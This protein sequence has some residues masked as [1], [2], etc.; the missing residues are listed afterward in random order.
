MN[1]INEVL[2]YMT[3]NLDES[4]LVFVFWKT[5]TAGAAK[6]KTDNLPWA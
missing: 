4:D 5:G 1:N 3:H 6:F 2:K